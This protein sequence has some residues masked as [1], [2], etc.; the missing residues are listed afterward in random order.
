MG[1]DETT[2]L[3][4]AINNLIWMHAPEGLTLAAAERM[5]CDILPMIQNGWDAEGL[6]AARLATPKP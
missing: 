3:K 2:D 6:P 5:A 4:L 1:D